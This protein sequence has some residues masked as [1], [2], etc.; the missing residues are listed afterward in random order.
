M[1]RHFLAATMLLLCT[2]SLGYAQDEAQGS[3]VLRFDNTLNSTTGEAPT[4]TSGVTFNPAIAGQGAL[5]TATSVLDY[6][7]ANKFDL[8]HGTIEFWIKPQWPSDDGRTNIFFR[9]DDRILIFKGGN[10]SVYCRLRHSAQSQF[11]M[12]GILPRAWAPGEWH[13]VA[14][15]WSLPGKIVLYA[16]GAAVSELDTTVQ[17]LFGNLPPAISFGRPDPNEAANALFDEFRISKIARSPKQIAAA[18]ISRLQISSLSSEADPLKLFRDWNVA[19]DLAAQTQVGVVRLPLTAAVIENENPGVAIVTQGTRIKA[20]ATGVTRIKATVNQATTSITVRVRTPARPPKADVL[21]SFLKTPAAGALYVIPVVLIKYLPTRDGINV[22]TE[23]SGYT[24]TLDDLNNRL[25]KDAIRTK[26]SLEEG[27][28]FRGYK[29]PQAKPSLGYRVVQSITIY[30][31]TPPGLRVGAPG[32]FFPDYHLI[33]HRLGANLLVNRGGVKEFWLWTY[34]H[35]NI[36]PVESNMSSP[37]TGDVSNSNR[38]NEDLPVYSRTYTLYNYNFAGNSNETV[39]DHGHQLEAIL[40]YVNERQDGNA[41]LFVNKF[42]GIRVN[43]PPPAGRSGWTH[44]PPNTVCEYDY[45]NGAL[46]PSDIETWKPEGGTPKPV[47]NLTWKNQPYQWVPGTRPPESEIDQPHWYIYWMQNMPGRNNTIPY[48]N[49]TMTNWWAFTGD[50]DG[51]IKSGLGLYN[52][53]SATRGFKHPAP[54]PDGTFI[55]HIAGPRRAVR[56][57]QQCQ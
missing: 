10:N 29:R 7:S 15:T 56:A 8:S 38:N 36:V 25:M 26:F 18:M 40:A 33:L 39:H 24:A 22:D 31:D 54:K 6:S 4:Q 16:D 13:H 1:K 2:V 17:S 35:G 44:S 47:N 55:S 53:P 14:V 5:L 50:W 43:N 52:D 27:S 32:L 21:P 34:H 42:A 19:T 11:E 20:L 51:S 9:V 57:A 3:F 49:G 30:E 37:T 45:A 46:F 23:V 28:R 48:G 41:D 12:A